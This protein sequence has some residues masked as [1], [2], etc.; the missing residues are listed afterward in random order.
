MTCPSCG[1]AVPADARFCPSCGHAIS[2]AQGDARRIV[3]VVFADL[4]GF[5]GLAEQL[6]PEQVKLLV[7]SAFE[8]LVD[9]VTAFGGRV[10]KLLGDGILALFGAPVAHEDDAERAV[11]AALRMQGTLGRY[12]EERGLAVPLQMRIGINTGEVLVGSLAGA[13]YTAMGDVVNTTSRIQSAAPAGAVLV[14]EITHALTAGVIDYDEANVIQPRGRDQP[15]TTWIARGE[16]APPGSRNRRMDLRL[17]GRTR[18]LTLADAAVH[19]ALGDSRGLL[20]NVSGESGVGKTRLV[21]E[22]LS[23]LDPSVGV[24]EGMCAPYG[25]SNVWFPIAS[26]FSSYMSLDPGRPVDD[27]RASARVKAGGLFGLPQDHPEVHELVEVFTHLLGFPSALD[28]SEVGVLREK[29]HRSVAK[30]LERRCE[31][32]PLVVWIDD[33]H[34][35]DQVVIDLLEHLVGCFGRLPFVLITSMRPTND[36]VWP[37]GYDRATVVSVSVQ[38]LGREASDELAVELLG[39]TATEGAADQ[40][41]LGALF[42]RSGGN[43]LFLQEL[44]VLVAKEGPTS[45]LPDSLRALIAARLDQLT[46]PERQVLDNAAVLGFSGYVGS[47]EQFAQKMHQDFDPALVTRLDS[48][49]FLTVDGRHWEFRSESVREAAYQMLTK[50][51]RAQRHAGVAASIAQHS[52]TAFD[53]LAHHTATAAEIVSELGTVPLVPPTIRTDAIGYLTAAAERAHETGSHRLVVKHTSR[54]IGLSREADDDTSVM[55]LRLLRSSALIELH[56][57]GSATTDLHAVLTEAAAR[58]DIEV[59]GEARA[60]HGSLHHLEGNHVAARLELGRAVELLRETNAATQLGAALRQ[61]GFIEL[62][63]G[64]LVDAEWYFGEAESVYRLLDDERGLAYVEQHRAWAAFLSGDLDLADTSLHHAADTLT[65]LGDRNGVGW[66]LGLLAFVR[67][68][69]RRF[70]EAEELAVVVGKEANDRGDDWA[71]AMMQ[72]LIADLRL[73][74]G[75]L[76]EALSNAEQA[77]NRFRRLGDKLGL[78]QALSALIRAQVGLGRVAAMNRSSEELLTL[79]EAS[80]MG[81]VPLLAVGGA[82]M[83]RGDAAVALAAVD[84][85]MT[86]M[87][88]VRSGSFES[89]VIRS[90]ALAQLG[91]IDEAMA[92]LEMLPEREREYPFARVASALVHGLTGD[93]DAALDEAGAVLADEGATYLDRAIAAVAAAGA[94]AARRDEAAAAAV[95]G[96]VI[97][98]VTAIGD[99]VAIALVLQAHLRILGRPHELGDGD[100]GALGGGWLD[101]VDAL[102]SMA[103]AA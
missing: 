5:T 61:R 85:A 76:E 89:H 78:I 67:F 83:H 57:F 77:R 47:L 62:F 39:E 3:T 4:V 11:R 32:G 18:E 44:A 23:H 96:P 93:L 75:K 36:I 94:H 54:A 42:D 87:G 49:G 26:A 21:D 97:T 9:D 1:S 69:Q 53:D 66:A 71:A 90:I 8:R 68:F 59:E 74:Q 46:A 2:S 31:K 25:Q 13:D 84:R 88:E 29:I 30:V 27:V 17:V 70:A 73:W 15:V 6:D 12:V 86:E 65:R 51:S 7:D 72:T 95:L 28:G 33:L 19:L 48:K 58:G 22:M 40:R 102:T 98:D 82:A 34:W 10:D 45:E 100:P 103:P 16:L 99:V 52:P 14:G 24:L 81:P 35:A 20:F 80:P 37:R 56:D 50:T 79:A 91:R 92:A 64:S 38:P 55:R 101:V 63:G 41:M 43:P 60:L